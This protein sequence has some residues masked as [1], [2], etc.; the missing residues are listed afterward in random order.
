MKYRTEGSCNSV[1]WRRNPNLILDNSSSIGTIIYSTLV[2]IKSPLA[3]ST[4]GVCKS[5]K[6]Y[7]D[8]TS[9]PK[10]S[11]KG[12]ENIDASVS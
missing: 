10:L 3:M 5:I 1:R 7:K 6:F 12:K 9:L 11:S 2:N 8:K 4:K